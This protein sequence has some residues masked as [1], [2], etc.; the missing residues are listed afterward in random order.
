MTF[1]ASMTIISSITFIVRYAASLDYQ[2]TIAACLGMAVVPRIR[3]IAAIVILSAVIDVLDFTIGLGNCISLAAFA[4][5]SI[6]SNTILRAMK[7]NP[8]EDLS[9][10]RG[11]GLGDTIHLFKFGC[12]IFISWHI[13]WQPY[14]VSNYYIWRHYSV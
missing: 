5:A 1:I 6:I 13:S 2:A 14:S 8:E 9:V 12:Y 10:T 11:A 3:N 4:I 7:I